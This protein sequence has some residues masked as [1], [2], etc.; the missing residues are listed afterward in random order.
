M[1]GLQPR[2]ALPFALLA[3]VAE[4]AFSSLLWAQGTDTALL[5]GTVTD[6]TGAVIPRA[7]VTMTDDATRVSNRIATDSAGR[8]TFNAL[9]PASYTA[10]VEAQGFKSLIQP[11]IVL[12]VG[13]QTDLNFSLQVGHTTE[14]VQVQAT[15]PLL[16]TVSA[17]LGTQVSR[18]Y[19]INLPLIDRNI[20]ELA[21]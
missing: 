10:T 21:Y 9:K 20:A 18:Q 3:C 2:F 7:T 4:I 5:R 13:Q 12:R 1:R 6:P 15:A 14:S 19:L 8:Y 16:D 17:A 11:G